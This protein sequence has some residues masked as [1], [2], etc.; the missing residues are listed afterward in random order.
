MTRI[1]CAPT[2]I[3]IPIHFLSSSRETRMGALQGIVLFYLCAALALS[4]F[5]E[6]S[7]KWPGLDPTKWHIHVING[8][9]GGRQL[10]VHCWSDIDD[11][12]FHTL[13]P[14][15]ET[16]WSFHVNLPG[17]TKFTCDWRAGKQHATYPV[18]WREARHMWL[19]SHCDW[20]ACFWTAKDDGIYLKNVPAG[21]DELIHPWET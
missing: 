10:V 15:G 17:T 2:N 11:L 14:G 6:S 21:V 16:N 5:P 9:S 12:G 20:K 8:F 18:F 1:S 4:I 19:R 3:R 7:A 13:N